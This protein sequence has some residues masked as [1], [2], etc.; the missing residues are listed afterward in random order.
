M[1]AQ[2]ISR[3]EL[4]KDEVRETLVHAGEAVYSHQQLVM[5]LLLAAVIVAA[6]ILGWKAYTQSQTVKAQSAFDEA[7]KVYQARVGPPTEMSLPGEPSFFSEKNKFADAIQKFGD[8]AKK[9]R[10]T[11]PGQLAAYYAG[12]SCERVDKLDDAS[13]WFAGLAGGA[14]DYAALARF[15]LAQLDDRTGKSADAVKLYQQLIA[16]PSV[17]V[18]KPVVMIALAEHY[19]AENPTEAAK[20]YMQVKA[21]YPDTGLA[22]QADQQ[23]ALLPG[24]I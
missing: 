12:L 20:L 23:L 14:D 9:Y 24:K 15:E 17:L 8:V 13:K 7:M 19:G 22:Q 3:R 5:Y 6:G 1:V 2:H 16:K 21:E 4:K 10:R 18:P 11:K